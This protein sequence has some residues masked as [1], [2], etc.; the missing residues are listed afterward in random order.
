MM[1][2]SINEIDLSPKPGKAYWVNCHREWREEIIYFLMVDRFHDS[3][4]RHSKNF[5]IRHPGFGNEDQ[6]QKPFGGTIKGIIN[7]IDYIKIWVVL[8]FG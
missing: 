8:P 2:K 5:D 4:A 6:L 7:N 1:I 3:E